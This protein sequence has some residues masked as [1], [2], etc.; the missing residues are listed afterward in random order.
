MLQVFLTDETCPEKW[1][2]RLVLV[3]ILRIQVDGHDF[4][5]PD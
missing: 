4:G 1:D 2:C 3:C 5:A